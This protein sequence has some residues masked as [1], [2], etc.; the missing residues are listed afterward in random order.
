MKFATLYQHGL[1]H[2]QTITIVTLLLKYSIG[3]LL[4]FRLLQG[5]S[6]KSSKFSFMKF[7]CIVPIFLISPLT[8]Q[9][10]ILFDPYYHPVFS[11]FLGFQV[12]TA[13]P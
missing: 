8:S 10:F 9:S 11:D 7:D 12:A 1:W 2:L 6:L 4:G 13:Y 3:F 5:E